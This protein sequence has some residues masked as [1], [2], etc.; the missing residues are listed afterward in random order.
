MSEEQPPRHPIFERVFDREREKKHP[1]SIA[2]DRDVERLREL[3][4]RIPALLRE[5]EQKPRKDRFLPFLLVRS[6]LNDNGT[7]PIGG[8]FWDSPDIWIAEGDPSVTPDLPA[9]PGGVIREGVPNTLYAHVWNLG[10]APIVGVRVEFYW[11][12]PS[13]AAN[14]AFI[15]LIGTTSVDLPPRV[16]LECHRL[17]KCRTPW[18]P[19]FVN[20][21]HECLFVRVSS[22]GD[23]IGPNEWSPWQ[24]RHVAQRNISV[25]QNGDELSQFIESLERTRPQEA[26]VELQEVGG[27]EAALAILL[28]GPVPKGETGTLAA[29]VKTRQRSVRRTSQALPPSAAK[30][31]GQVLAEL[32]AEGRLTTPQIKG[33]VLIE[34]GASLEDLIYYHERLPA[35]TDA[36]TAEAAAADNVQVLRLLTFIGTELVGGYTMV[37]VG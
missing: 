5:E 29:P 34:R 7:R 36:S 32:T 3:E 22:I 19:E 20:N 13:L 9:G 17:V 4:E 21:G 1:D 8:V 28:A 24:N 15:H 11:C 2:D 10:L 35:N 25:I 23:P 27:E 37:V 12:D 33:G 14:P 16:S 6:I 26:R 18:I 31:K 30:G